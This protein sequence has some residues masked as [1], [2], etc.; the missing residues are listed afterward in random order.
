MSR[1]SAVL[2]RRVVGELSFILPKLLSN[3]DEIEHI[4]RLSYRPVSGPWLCTGIEDTIVVLTLHVKSLTDP[5]STA[6]PHTTIPPTAVGK[7]STPFPAHNGQCWR[8]HPSRYSTISTPLTMPSIVMP[9]LL[10]RSSP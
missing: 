5:A 8:L 7:T 10:R 9:I 4:V 1:V 3:V 6:R 2:S